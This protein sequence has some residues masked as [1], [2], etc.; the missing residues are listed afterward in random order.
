MGVGQGK[1]EAQIWGLH[2]SVVG[3]EPC[4]RH[5]EPPERSDGAEVV[6]LVSV[7]DERHGWAS[8]VADLQA[9]RADSYCPAPAG[10]C[11][12]IPHYV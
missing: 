10:V 3:V 8:R 4:Q 5:A 11:T 1:I 6:R 9:Y 2:R 7:T 12:I